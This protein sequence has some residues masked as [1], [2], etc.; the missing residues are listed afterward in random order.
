V[1]GYYETKTFYAPTYLLANERLKKDVRTTIFWEPTIT[2]NQQGEAT[3][4]F[5]NADPAS[6]IKIS[7]QGIAEKGLF[8]GGTTYNV[9]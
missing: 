7:A 2:T 8:T 9:K 1:D 3:L 6:T 5:Y 4:S